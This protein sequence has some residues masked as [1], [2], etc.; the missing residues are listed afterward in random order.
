MSY[1][2]SYHEVVLCKINIGSKHMS[3][4]SGLWE[5]HG[6]DGQEGNTCHVQQRLFDANVSAAAVFDQAFVQSDVLLST[7]VNHH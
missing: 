2:G 1:I 6:Q 3:T 7:M 4:A 5:G